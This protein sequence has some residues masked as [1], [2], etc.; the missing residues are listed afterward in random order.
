MTEPRWI[1]KRGLVLLHGASLAEHGGLVGIRDDGLLESAL[2]RPQNQYTCE[3]V[4]TLS[5]LAA[6]YA[7]GLSENHPFNDGN[8]RAAFLAAVL[9]LSKNGFKFD[10]SQ[11]VAYGAI[12][13]LSAGE[14]SEDEL[15]G[16]IR[17]NVRPK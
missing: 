3:G 10:T 9:F 16:W 15:A 11:T 4:T 17:D 5:R 2:T 12:M 6:A 13:A 14:L 7:F 1:T 8:E